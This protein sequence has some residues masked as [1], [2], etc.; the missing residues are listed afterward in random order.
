M[1]ID[2]RLLARLDREAAA[3][4][5]SRSAYL[6]EL[7]ARQLPGAVGPGK[8][9]QAHEALRKLDGLFAGNPHGEDSTRAIRALRDSR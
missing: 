1:P 4:G 7:V 2:D 5:V 8:S 3:R 6:S 9:R